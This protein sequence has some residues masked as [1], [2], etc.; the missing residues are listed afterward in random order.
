[1]LVEE[2]ANVENSN[3]LWDASAEAGQKLYK[4]GDLLES[5]IADLDIYLLKKVKI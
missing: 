4:K 5:G 2:D 1:M 3:K